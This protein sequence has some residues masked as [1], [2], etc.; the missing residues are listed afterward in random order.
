MT[1]E[2]NVIELKSFRP[3]MR[4]EEGLR[5]EARERREQKMLRSE[6]FLNAVETVVTCAIGIGFTVCIALFLTML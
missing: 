5:R 3:E 4:W 6:R 1:C 2:N